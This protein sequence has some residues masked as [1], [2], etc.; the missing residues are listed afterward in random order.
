[1]Y[2]LRWNREEANKRCAVMPAPCFQVVVNGKVVQDASSTVEVLGLFNAEKHLVLDETC[3]A[4]K[5]SPSQP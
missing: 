4:D 3:V 2:C 1:M 5:E